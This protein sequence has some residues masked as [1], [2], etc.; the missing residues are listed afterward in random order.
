MRMLRFSL[1]S[2]L[3]LVMLGTAG[4]EKSYYFNFTLEKDLL[5]NDGNWIASNDQFELT[6]GGLLMN[7]CYILAPHLYEGDVEVYV[8][9]NLDVDP[10]SSGADMDFSL[11]SPIGTDNECGISI[12]LKNLG[13]VDEGYLISNSGG[14]QVDMLVP[15]NAPIPGLNNGEVNVLKIVRKLGRFYFYINDIPVGLNLDATLYTSN[16]GCLWMLCQQDPMEE[17]VLIKDV[18]IIYEG[19]RFLWQDL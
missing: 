13:T 7:G 10:G 16:L 4:C 8:K 17:Q 15:Y 6:G 12:S 11:Y 14:M 1:I 19:E 2:A 3:I 18:K 9:F 5:R